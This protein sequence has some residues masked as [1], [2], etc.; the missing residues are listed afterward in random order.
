MGFRCGRC[1][2]RGFLWSSSCIH[3]AVGSLNWSSAGGT[4]GS[5]TC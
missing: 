3:Y 5:A 2:W 1:T 4:G